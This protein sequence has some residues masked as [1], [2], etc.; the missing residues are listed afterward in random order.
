ML[1]AAGFPEVRILAS[2][3]LDEQVIDSIRDEGGRVDIYGV[4][5]RLATGSGAG[6]VALGGVYKLVELNKQPRMKF[7]SDIAKATLPGGKRVLRAVGPES[8]FIQDVI[9]LEGGHLPQPGDRVYDPVN[10]LRS[11]TLPGHARLINLRQVV[12]EAGEPTLAPESLE[13]LAARCRREMALLPAGCLRFIN[14]HRYK[15]SISTRLKQQ[16]HDMIEAAA[17][18]RQ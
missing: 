12:M 14:P 13:V 8:E 3:E 5:T 9:C 7:T 16:R 18:G 2:N 4:G 15:V 10:P 17:T 11:T 6:G 1:D